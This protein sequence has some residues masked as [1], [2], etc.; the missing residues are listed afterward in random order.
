MTGNERLPLVDLNG[1][2]VGSARRAEAHGDPLLLHPVVHCIVV[3]RNG[4]LLLQLRS[5][6]KDVQPGRWDTSVGGHV[7]LG[8]TIESAIVREIGE[9]LGAT[10]QVSELRPLY[11]YV[12]QSAIETELVHSYLWTA[13]GP[14]RPEPLEID[15]LRFWTPMEIERELGTGIFTPN[16]EDEFS[17]YQRWLQSDP[18]Q[19]GDGR[20]PNY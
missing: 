8:E 3:S 9:E 6:C 4:R 12:M 5:K 20:A 7:N 2:V 15:E 11:R 19:T 1:R 13:D 10:V 18:P 16:F 17:R 14:F